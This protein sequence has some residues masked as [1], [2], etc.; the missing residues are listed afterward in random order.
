MCMQDQAPRE[1]SP[2][3]FSIAI[4][5]GELGDLPEKLLMIDF[6]LHVEFII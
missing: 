4:L 1:R 6:D 5:V 3:K 2:T